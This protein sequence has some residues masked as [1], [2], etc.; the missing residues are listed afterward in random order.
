MATYTCTK[1]G[2]KYEKWQSM[3]YGNY[4]CSEYAMKG[5]KKKKM[6]FGLSYKYILSF[7][8]LI[9]TICFVS[10]MQLCQEKQDVA[11]IPCLGLTTINDCSGENVSVININSS[12]RYNLTTLAVGD[13]TSNFTFNFSEIASYSLIDCA[14]FTATI[15]VGYFEGGFGI[16]QFAFLI[17][18][19]IIIG[20]S[21][22]GIKLITMSYDD[23][24]ISSFRYFMGLVVIII[25]YL[26]VLFMVGTINSYIITYITSSILSNLYNYFY[27]ALFY[28]FFALVAL[29][30]ITF[31]VVLTRNHNVTKYG[32]LMK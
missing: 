30:G 6:G 19:L 14:N 18:F 32:S 26:A 1:C 21:L 22:F 3:E 29:N 13:G 2:K 27:S 5:T 9:L 8:L 12:S 16:I 31:M 24:N 25:G 28:I 23:S 20:V 11:D 4:K 7:I 17:P 15:V 10:S